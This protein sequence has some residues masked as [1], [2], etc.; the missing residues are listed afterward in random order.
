[1]F[2]KL[3]GAIFSAAMLEGLL[4]LHRM[5]AEGDDRAVTRL[6]AD[7]PLRDAASAVGE[8]IASMPTAAEVAPTVEALAASRAQARRRA[9]LAHD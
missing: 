9:P 2:G 4:P 3:W 8:S 1:M 5:T 7:A 6:L